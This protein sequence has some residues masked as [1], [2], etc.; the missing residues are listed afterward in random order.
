MATCEKADIVAAGLLGITELMAAEA[1]GG[2]GAQ[3][4][5]RCMTDDCDA[6]DKALRT[7]WPETERLL[8]TFHIGQVHFTIS[9]VL[10]LVRWGPLGSI[11]IYIFTDEI[12]V[13]CC[14][15]HCNRRSIWWGAPGHVPHLPSPKS[16]PASPY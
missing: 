14:Q 1:F 9:T 13:M 6:E 16:G 7:A 11:Y 10:Q 12:W 4:P 5:Q 15:M 3:G 8:C 2:R